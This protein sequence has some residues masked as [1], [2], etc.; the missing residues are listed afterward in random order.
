MN[1]Y[2]KI[3]LSR[4]KN[5][6][7][8]DFIALVLKNIYSSEK[9]FIYASEI[10]NSDFNKN[11]VFD[12]LYIRK[13]KIDDLNEAEKYLNKLP[14]EFQCHRFDNVNDFFIAINNKGIQH[15]SWIY[16]STNHNRILM[17]DENSVEIKF[18]LTLPNFRG[19]G[20]YPNVIYKIKQFLYN[21]GV[22]R[23][24]MCV[25]EDNF[26]SI[27]GIEKAGFELVGRTTLNKL[28]CIQLSKKINMSEVNVPWK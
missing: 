18:C 14:W 1:R 3:L 15:I 28:L 22:K 16:Y 6:S 2:I 20:I 17:L 19:K 8:A 11:T 5:I 27:K 4:V 25:N 26:S 7:L 9:L 23:A 21:K 24:F 12:N 10:E 13:G